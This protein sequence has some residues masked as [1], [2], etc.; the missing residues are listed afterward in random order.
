[1]D[2]GRVELKN[3]GTVMSRDFYAMIKM[4]IQSLIEAQNFIQDG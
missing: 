3:C 2:A 1:M 4:I